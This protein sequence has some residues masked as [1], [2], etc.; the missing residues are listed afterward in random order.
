MGLPSR[1]LLLCLSVLLA[2][3]PAAAEPAS[4][5]AE[6]VVAI[7]PLGKV[8]Q[9]VLDRVAKEI[10][11][12]L[13]VQIR[14]ESPRELPK[15]AWYAPRKRWRAEKLLEAIDADPPKGAWK[16]VAVTEGEISTTK[17]D[18]HDW[19]IAGLGNMGGLSCVLSTHIYRKHSKTKA[20]LLRRVGDLTIHEFGH[21]L[22]FDHCETDG[23]V[24]ADAKG[25]A[26]SSADHS[27]GNYCG[28]CLGQLSPEV[29]AW[30]KEERAAPA[31]H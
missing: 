22:G 19:G 6:P 23:C 18:I 13:R 12:R 3:L 1:A 9:D 17:G 21:T 7:L 31:P 28:R 2:G 20:V 24:M 14:F 8:D 11:A 5:S 30:M 27:S 26:I 16:V 25:K 29:R 4:P 10:Q 15:A